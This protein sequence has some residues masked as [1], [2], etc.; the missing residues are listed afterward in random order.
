MRFDGSG[1]QMR[2]AQADSPLPRMPLVFLSR[3]RLDLPT[4]W[5]SEAVQRLQRMY[6]ATQDE[7]A[8]LVP[9]ARHEIATNS[10]HYIQL[11][12]PK[13]VVDAIRRVV[14]RARAAH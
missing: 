4:D 13:L 10:G 14:G 11:D 2:R 6:Q 12:R 8:K 3:P 1:A 7:L 9:G 5:Q